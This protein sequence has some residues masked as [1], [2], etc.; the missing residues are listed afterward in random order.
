LA[1]F[2]AKPVFSKG[3]STK[4]GTIYMIYA[5]VCIAEEDYFLAFSIY[6]TREAFR[7]IPVSSR[8][9]IKIDGNDGPL[10]PSAYRSGK[11]SLLIL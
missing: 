8:S 4:I 3:I 11:T 1:A 2:I 9:S 7:A 5:I 6:G 10:A